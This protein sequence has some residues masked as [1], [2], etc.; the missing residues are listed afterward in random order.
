MDCRAAGPG[1]PGGGAFGAQWP[2]CGESCIAPAHSA[3]KTGTQLCRRAV[4]QGLSSRD[5]PTAPPA[6]NAGARRGSGARRGCGGRGRSAERRGPGTRRES[7]RRRGSGTAGFQPA[8]SF[9]QTWCRGHTRRRRQRLHRRQRPHAGLRVAAPDEDSPRSSRRHAASG[10]LGESRYLP[11]VREP[12]LRMPLAVGELAGSCGSPR[13]GW[14]Q[15][16]P[17]AP[18]LLQAALK[19]PPLHQRLAPPTA[20][21]SLRP[22]ADKA[23]AGAAG[24][25][26]D[27]QK[28]N[29]TKH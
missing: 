25:A 14:G 13:Q 27:L 6:P 17:Y 24:R 16:Q 4:A 10:C 12:P 20:R 11:P 22:R 2:P 19:R 21:S 5:Q 15:P 3:T 1:V 18:L 8:P 29:W 28:K 23:V 9:I 26:I 7:G